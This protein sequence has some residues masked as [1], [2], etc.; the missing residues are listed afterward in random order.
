MMHSF[1]STG[2]NRSVITSGRR[3]DGD[4]RTGD[5]PRRSFVAF[6]F[7]V[8]RVRVDAFRFRVNV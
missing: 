4:R 1:L 3:V 2:I 8:R 5:T 7:V 6:A